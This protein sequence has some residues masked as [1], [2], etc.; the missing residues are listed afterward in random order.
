MVLA[1]EHAQC[2]TVRLLLGDALGTQCQLAQEY[3]ALPPAVLREALRVTCF[4]G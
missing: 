3:N 4:E 2:V 1:Q